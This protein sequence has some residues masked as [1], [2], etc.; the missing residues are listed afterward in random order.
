MNKKLI[1]INCFEDFMNTFGK[2]LSESYAQKV[3][4]KGFYGK[5]FVEHLTELEAFKQMEQLELFDDVS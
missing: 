1:Q 3:F 2:P 4:R 5:V